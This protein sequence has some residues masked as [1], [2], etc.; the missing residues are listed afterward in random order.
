MADAYGWMVSFQILDLL[1]M[2]TIKLQIRITIS[3]YVLMGILKK[4]MSQDWNL[5]AIMQILGITKQ[6]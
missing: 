4:E 3:S 2:K 6:E 1:P 5:N